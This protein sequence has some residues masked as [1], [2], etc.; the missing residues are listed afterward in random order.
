MSKDMFLGSWHWFFI[1]ISWRSHLMTSDQFLSCLIYVFMLI[2]LSWN[3]VSVSHFDIC[4]VI[5]DNLFL[6]STKTSKLG[7]SSFGMMYAYTHVIGQGVWI[8]Y[9]FSFCPLWCQF[10]WPLTSEERSKLHLLI[11]WLGHVNT[12]YLRSISLNL[13]T[14]RSQIMTSDQR[15]I[16]WKGVWLLLHFMH[17]GSVLPYHKRYSV[18]FWSRGVFEGAKSESGRIFLIPPPWGR[19]QGGEGGGDKGDF[20]KLTYNHV[21]DV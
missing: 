13:A 2:S 9:S 14:W 21:W 4:K 11:I 17:K 18:T 5:S 8:S 19:I 15:Q 7:L 1:L 3:M 6:T 12:H 20:T 16:F 10:L